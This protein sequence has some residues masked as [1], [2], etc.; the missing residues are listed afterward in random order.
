MPQT[1]PFEIFA[2]LSAALLGFSGLMIALRQAKFTPES[3][4]A[5]I[6][7]LLYTAG[8]ALVAS[9]LPLIN[10]PLLIAC[11]VLLLIMVSH[12]SWAIRV[13][14]LNARQLGANPVLGWIFVTASLP[15]IAWLGVALFR[16]IDT[17][18]GAY[19]AAIGFLLLTSTYN[20]CRF[21]MLSLTTERPESPPGE[22]S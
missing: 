4:A 16:D 11:L 21:L 12:S 1:A 18:L 8:G 17:Q 15:I 22:D 14:M 20:F 13:W 19:I 6:R 10:V 5:R 3:L 2:E 7:G 9:L